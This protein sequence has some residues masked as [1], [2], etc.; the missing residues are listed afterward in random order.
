MPLLIHQE[1]VSKQS[2]LVFFDRSVWIPRFQPIG[3]VNQLAQIE[4]FGDL[5]NLVDAKTIGWNVLQRLPAIIE[6][7][8]RFALV[9][10]Q[11]AGL[12]RP[13][14]EEKSVRVVAVL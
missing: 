9:L 12:V 3:C 8:D 4:T 14:D 7:V 10:R 11:H 13:A 5:R 6:L 2:V 1:E